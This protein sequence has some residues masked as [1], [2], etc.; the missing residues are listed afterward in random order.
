MSH[1]TK[2]NSVKITSIAALE[3]AVQTLNNQKG[4]N[5]TV[6]R[7]APC[8]LWYE[9][10]Q[11]AVVVDVPGVQ[12]GLNVGFEGNEQTG[13]TPIF[14]AHGGW[15]AKHIGGGK[16]LA[17]TTEE[18]QLANIGALMHAY[19]VEAVRDVAGASGAMITEE[20]N[21]ATGETVMQLV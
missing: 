7:N 19:A 20:F 1:T 18:R 16:A 13:L 15:I 3:R 12:M 5:L 2:V 6:R 14:D 10:R 8:K 21:P 11:C 17:K 9:N 4:L